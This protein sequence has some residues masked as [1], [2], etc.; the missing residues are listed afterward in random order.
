M[1]A[2]SVFF[3]SLGASILTLLSRVSS[4]DLRGNSLE[5]LI[6]RE[7]RVRLCNLVPISI[8]PPPSVTQDKEL[9]LESLVGNPACSSGYTW[10]G[11]F[12]PLPCIAS[13]VVLV[14]SLLTNSAYVDHSLCSP[15][16]FFEILLV[17]AFQVGVLQFIWFTSIL[18]N[19]LVYR[20]LK[21]REG[22]FWLN[23]ASVF[24]YRPPTAASVNC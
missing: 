16:S 23:T 1:K 2:M 21:N 7:S 24:P 12:N 10:T 11:L 17:D 8:S 13:N 3:L 18:V 15:Q 5:T 22:I 19:N 14:P 20:T 6:T 4:Q 9:G